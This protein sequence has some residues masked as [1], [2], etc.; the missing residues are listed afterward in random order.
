MDTP[1]SPKPKQTLRQRQRQPLLSA[2]FAPTST[3]KRVNTPSRPSGAN[4]P[5]NTATTKPSPQAK[6][7]IVE[8]KPA[9]LIP[10]TKESST[11]SGSLE[12]AVEC[13]KKDILYAEL[14]EVLHQVASTTKRLQKSA[15][16]VDLF[17]KVFR[18]SPGSLLPCYYLASDSIAPDYEGKELKVGHGMVT[19]V[20]REATGA[21]RA[22]LHSIYRDT[23][24]IGDVAY[25]LKTKQGLL[26]G[27]K[28]ALTVL[29]I[30]NALI[31]VSDLKGAGSTEQRK[32]I[33]LGVFHTLSGQEVRYFTRALIRNSRVGAS[34][35]SIVEAIACASLWEREGK[36]PSD[37]ELKQAQTDIRAAFSVLPDIR[38]IVEA[39]VEGGMKQVRES[40]KM[41]V[42]IPVEPML[43]R[44]C[45][46]V[47][48]FIE[49][50]GEKPFLCEFKYDG[51]RI[52]IH[53]GGETRF[54]SFSRHCADNTE[55]F[56]DAGQ[57]VQLATRG[58]SVSSCILDAEV[59]ATDRDND[60]KILAFQTLST[61][62]RKN[63]DAANV[64]VDVCIVAFDLLELNGESLL[65]LP[66]SERRQR[67]EQNFSVVP[68]VFQVVDYMRGTKESEES[69]IAFLQQ[70]ISASCEG[71]VVK[72]C[73]SVYEP[74]KRSADW[75]KLKQDYILS[76]GDKVPRLIGGGLGDTL[77]LVP[78]GGWQGNG[79]KAKWI[80]P[81]LLAC[82]DPEEDTYYSVCRVMS[83]FS[84]S[85]YKEK[86]EQFLEESDRPLERPHNYATPERASYW[87]HPTEVWEIRGAELT[88]SPRHQ[89]G[90]GLIP[91]QPERG[92]SIR[93][94]RFIKV[95]ED[96]KPEMATTP[97]QIADMFIAQTR[98][99]TKPS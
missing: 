92:V 15:L 3:H 58:R 1:A 4:S 5:S 71:L 52:Q 21:T 23:G 93:F 74:S 63:V 26:F 68:G 82:Y 14:C 89:A 31:K 59:V 61:R 87:F 85:F 45:H 9:S 86:T 84:D 57:A 2:F 7:A 83:G 28:K 38:K 76:L 17:R 70:A 66:L 40:C 95:R 16:L 22:K 88:S 69:L 13:E 81:F 10:G 55:Q 72:S 27:R 6:E 12:S 54:R 62:Q 37:E 20:I 48:E 90:I 78:I 35:L 36:K 98:R 75:F 29:Q 41:Q 91:M 33:I 80:S 79:R 34:K 24:D 97:R 18:S 53:M 47:A 96:K 42:G 25:K 65:S 73:D 64:K 32:R 60:N 51:Q 30:Y 39:L 8:P 99:I 94:P 67:L 77:D 43:A 44:V 46:S 56:P 50:F 49:T 19:A 11:A